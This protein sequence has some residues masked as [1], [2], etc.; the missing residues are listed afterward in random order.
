MENEEI[1]FDE[2]EKEFDSI[3]SELDYLFQGLDK[4]FNLWDVAEELKPKLHETE[5]NLNEIKVLLEFIKTDGYDKNQCC[6]AVYCAILSIFEGFIHELLLILNKYEASKDKSCFVNR[7]NKLENRAKNKFSNADEVIK[8][9]CKRTVNNP[10]QVALL[11]NKLFGFNINNSYVDSNKIINYRNSYT[12]RNGYDKKRKKL[13]LSAADVFE[14]YNKLYKLMSDISKNIRL[15]LDNHLNSFSQVYD[16][17]NKKR[18]TMTQK[19]EM[20]DRKSVV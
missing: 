6:A 19:F 18:A 8:Y 5:D 11:F 2:F 20:A 9:Y 12:H 3:T 15:Y 4:L 10:D 7:V 17:D 13:P 14:L 1:D 16:L